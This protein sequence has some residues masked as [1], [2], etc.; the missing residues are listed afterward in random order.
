MD[1]LK[2]I[3]GLFADVPE[4]EDVPRARAALTER[5]ARGRKPRFA[6]YGLLAAAAAVAVAA[7]FAVQGANAPP[8]SAKDVLL[9]AADASADATPIT[10]RP[11]QFVHTVSRIQNRT[12]ST[13]RGGSIWISSADEDR[14]IPTTHTPTWMTRETARAPEAAPGR[15][16]PAEAAKFTGQTNDTVYE[17]CTTGSDADLEYTKINT[18]PADPDQLRE[19]IGTDGDKAWMRLTDLAGQSVLRPELQSA[20]FRA[21]ADFKGVKV[22]QDATDAAGRPA[23]AVARDSERGWQD[24]LLFGRDDYRYLG[25]QTVATRPIAPFKEVTISQP[26]GTVLVASALMSV[27]VVDALPQAAPKAS[28]MKIPC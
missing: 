12:F 17:S 24:R 23:I 9:R 5:I 1:E 13:L 14:W 20:L 28:H 16:L 26:A 22:V 15:E 10:V 4:P 3:A 18:W 19:R 2:Q 6:R 7:A 25:T 11:G 27:D 8:A 21:A